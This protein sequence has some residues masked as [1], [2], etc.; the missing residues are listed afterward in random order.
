MRFRRQVSGREPSAADLSFGLSAGAPRGAEAEATGSTVTKNG[1]ELLQ[2]LI[3]RGAAWVARQRDLHRPGAMMLDR[4]AR[5]AL[6][7]FFGAEVLSSACFKTVARIE[8][9]EFY[10]HLRA[11][12]VAIPLDFTTMEGITFVDTVLV[13]RAPRSLVFHELV[14][15]VQYR[16]LGA[17]EFVHRYVRGWAANGYQYAAIPLERDAYALQARFE[18][19]PAAGFSVEKEVAARLLRPQ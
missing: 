10:A 8:N 18:A 14:H 15:V 19:D 2:Y 9:P 3:E 11:R 4:E 16:V 5:A 12:G 13:K 17:A 7:P 1:E 6:A